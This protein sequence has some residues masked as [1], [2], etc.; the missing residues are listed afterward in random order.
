MRSFD[1]GMLVGIGLVVLLLIVNVAITYQNTCT[2]KDDADW[3][4]HSD[5]V[6][7]QT[8]NVMLLLVDMETSE[9]GYVITGEK[10]FLEPYQ[11][12]K[13]QLDQH[14]AALKQ[15][16]ADNAELQPSLE[17]LEQLKDDR[18]AL[19]EKAIALR[20]SGEEAAR[21][22]IA[23][24]QGKQVMDAIRGVVG[25]IVAQERQL[26]QARAD[27]SHRGYLFALYSEIMAGLLALALF[28][29]FIWYLGQALAARQQDAA[30]I[31]DQREWFRTTLASIGDAVIA[32]DTHGN[33]TFLNG[34]GESL[35]GWNGQE[36]IG[37]PLETVFKIVNEQTRRKTENPVGR[38]LREGVV[39]GLANHTVL[40]SKT[41]EEYPIEDSAAPIR[42]QKGNVIGVVL[43]FHSVSERREAEDS[44]KKS[45]HRFRLAADAV[46]GIIYD[47][48]VATGIMHRTRGLIE[49]TGFDPDEVPPTLEWWRERIHPDDLPRVKEEWQQAMAGTS[50]R[51]TCVYRARHK[52]GHW[53]HVMDRAVMERDAAGSVVRIIGCRVDISE[54]KEAEERLRENDRRKD[55]FLATLAHELRNPLA[56]LRNALEVM[57]LE[58]NNPE[59]FAHLNE[60]MERQLEH[61]VRLVDDLLN[62][63][64]ITRGKIELR[65]ERLDVAKVIE[66]ALETSRPLVEAGGHQLSVAQSPTPVYVIGRPDAAGP[67]RLESAQQFGQIHAAGRPDSARRRARRRRSADPSARQRPRH[68]RRNAR[69]SVR[70][71]YPSRSDARTGPRGPRHRADLGAPARG[72]ARRPRRGVQRRSRQGERV[73]HPSARCP[74]RCRNP[75][76]D[77]FDHHVSAD[78][79][80]QHRILVVDDNDDS[81]TSLAML[82][83]MMGGEVRTAVD[84]PTAL[85]IARQF[86][87]EVVL[88]DLG[89][90]VMN[91]YEVGRRMREM[92]EA[93]GAILVAQTGWGQDEDRRRSAE[94]GFDAHLVKPVDP[95]ALQKILSSLAAR[96]SANGRG[97]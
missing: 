10:E 36:A 7:D 29:A 2:L 90:P 79:S 72:N 86:R 26:R 32:T 92:P 67:S 25:D 49:V 11:S 54:Q 69:Q 13:E 17:K 34:V 55:E 27:L 39:A 57:R 9:R 42:D 75:P 82:V 46:D 70:H 33:V 59:M 35:T 20:G 41:G 8:A 6:L 66:S 76:T 30:A 93:Q 50:D 87:P 64:R 3:V 40:V 37:Q 97:R 15:L 96:P 95:T 61:L 28:G 88:L 91:G 80:A 94:A 22:L 58:P 60:I 62:V 21:T 84:G 14:F 47:I 68:P 23:S 63:S 53:L 56:P 4:D 77:G 85:E 24:K 31:R 45:E 48:D 71:V 83:R 5:Q 16:T 44:L 78:K 89:L 38:V 12:A 43:V 19:V 74:R 51:L 18:I 73:C 52:D 81:L 65:K 1:R